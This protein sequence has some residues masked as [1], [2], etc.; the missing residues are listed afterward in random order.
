MDEAAV[1]EL[2]GG[3][4]RAVARAISAVECGGASAR[5]VIAAIYRFTGRA[6]VI[7]VTGAPGTGKSTLVNEIALV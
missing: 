1:E 4:A 2:R 3:S 5:E 6:H 7:G